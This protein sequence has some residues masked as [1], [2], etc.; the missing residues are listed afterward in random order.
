MEN[1]L[2][3]EYEKVR[4]CL[5]KIFDEK[6]ENR[7]LKK[8]NLEEYYLFQRRFVDNESRNYFY[9]KKGAYAEYLKKK[10]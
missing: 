1:F 3:M 8:T 10:K 4:V 9:S 7:E 6:E 5:Y 2:S